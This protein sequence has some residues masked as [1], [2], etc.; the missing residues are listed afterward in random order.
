MSDDADLLC[1]YADD[2][3]EDAFTELVRRHVDLVYSSAL[4]Q[5]RG[6]HHRAQEVTQMVFVDLARKA[7]AL[8]R[9]PVLAAWLHRSS[10]FAALE[11]YRKEGRRQKYENAAATEAALAAQGTEAAMWEGVGP[12]LDE[13]INTLDERDRQAILLRYFGNQPFAAVGN[14]MKLSENA[15]RMRVGRA[16]EKLRSVLAQRGIGSST[17]AL[18]I[19]LSGRAVA[20]APAGV[21]AASASAAIGAGGAGAA[22]I[23]FMSTAKLPV[24]VAAAILVG[25]TAVIA[26]QER[27]ANRT[28]EEAADLARQNRSIPGLSE[29]NQRLAAASDQ[30]R[31]LN[32]D[33]ATVSVL[34]NQLRQAEARA[35]ATPSH[36]NPKRNTR[37]DDGQAVIDLAKLDQRPIMVTQTRPEYPPALRQSGAE[38]EAVVQFVV[39]SDGRVYNAS[40]VSFTD[41]AFADAAVQAVS[42]WVFKPGQV[43]GQ[44]VYT[45]MQVPIVFT[46]SQDAPRP[47]SNSWF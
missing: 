29:T 22:W 41:Q 42:G 5:T 6:D 37:L 10:H 45:Q 4:R 12:V 25:G 11:L 8:V 31:D 23:T 30:A 14:R 9:H 3:A 2:R 34:R 44:N 28:A 15:A 43:G 20:A 47:G 21:A 16:L 19:A 35:G 33:A 17:A 38:G 27:S 39:G 46:L 36:Q 1:R 13:A 7:A 32:D 40:A 26:L 24:A 18:A